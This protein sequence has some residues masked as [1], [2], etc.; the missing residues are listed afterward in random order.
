[1]GQAYEKL[2]RPILFR[3]DAERAH[4]LGAKAL[5]ALSWAVPVT[6]CMERLNRVALPK[7]ITL[8]GKTFSNPVGLA[9]GMDKNGTFWPAASGLGFGFAE[10]GTV[11]AQAQEGNPKPRLFRY[12]KEEAVINRMGFNND[13]AE[14]VA[15]RLKRMRPLRKRGFPLGINIGKSRTTP[16]EG[17][18]EDYVFSFKKLASYADYIAINV[19]SPN[20]PGL[21]KL[22]EV[23]HLRELFK[24]LQ[25]ENKRRSERVPLLVKI[26]P[27]LSYAEIDG[28]LGLIAECN[29]DGI[30]ATNTTLA[31]P[32][33]LGVEWEAGGLSGE[34]LQRK[35]YSI[36]KY[37]SKVTRGQLPIIGVG[38]IS[39]PETAGRAMDAGAHLIQVY[40]SLIYKGPGLVPELA[41]A[42]RPRYLSAL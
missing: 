27:D 28:I 26:A 12:P 13:G 7:P 16:L 32:K 35:S 38:G 5:E 31:R 37:I 30:I 4:V 23:A 19:S 14:Q 34:P 36:I 41:R 3:M 42:L 6:Y 1:M 17:A 20:T 2:I 15:L 9:A 24:A 33:V 18:I 25:S 11:T 22:Q 40:T 39:D 29:I 10:I 21:R 8:W